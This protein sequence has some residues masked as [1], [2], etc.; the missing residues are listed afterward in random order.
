MAK[1][2]TCM[3]A[4]FSLL[5]VSTITSSETPQFNSDGWKI[6]AKESRVV[7][8]LRRTS[9]YL[10]DGVAF[11]QD[12]HFTDGVIEFDLAVTAERGSAE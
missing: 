1:S 2:S 5:V 12:S 6:Q 9:L 8:H 7:D 11:V 3:V 4:A 10:K